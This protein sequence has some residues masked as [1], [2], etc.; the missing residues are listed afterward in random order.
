MPSSCT[1][2]T[3]R[4]ARARTSGCAFATATPKPAQSRSSRSFSPS[5]PATVS[6]GV[7]PRRSATKA[8]PLPLLTSGCANSRKYGSDFEMNSRPAKRGFSSASSALSASGSPTATS[9]VG[10]A[11]EP[12]AQVADGVDGD[13]LELRVAP[14]L[15]VDLGDVEVVV[16]VRVEVEAGVEHCVHRLARVGERDRDVE[17]EL[18]A[19]RIGDDRALVTD[20]GIVEP[21]LLEVRPHGAEH[22]SRHDD[23]VRAGVANGAERRARARPQHAVLGD[24]RP[25]EIEGEGGDVPRESPPEGLR[26]RAAGGL[27]RRTPRR[28]RPAA[29]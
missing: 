12:R 25:V 2:G 20:D 9:F 22:P 5:P 8:R 26:S 19:R 4:S 17:E 18:A 28:P 1:G 16:D 7:N 14:R 10:V 24:Q 23:H 15:G 27:R 29:S 13:V 21:R 3:M 11:R 6:A